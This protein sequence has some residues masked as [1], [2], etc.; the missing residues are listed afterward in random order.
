VV[1]HIYPSASDFENLSALR[2]ESSVEANDFD[3]SRV[4]VP[5]PWGYEY[6]WF[7]NSSVA[8][9]MLHLKPGCSTSLHCHARKRTSLIVMEG[10]VLCSTIDDRYHL[11]EGEAAVLEPCVFHSSQAISK[12]NVFLMEVETPPLKGD[13]LRSKDAFGRSGKAYESSSQYS[14]ELEK[15]DYQP[16][17]SIRQQEGTFNF[18]NVILSLSSFNGK[19]DFEDGLISGGI[20]VPLLG[21]IVFGKQTV[22]DIGEAITS[23]E[24]PL[25]ACPDSIP[26]V[27]LLQI[28]PMPNKQS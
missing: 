1:N 21:R 20:S 15:Y 22:A 2:T 16:L 8:I 13:L 27:E 4:V 11:K 18:K 19:S 7:Q 24:I 9:W 3:Y 5:K 28:V 10:N 14:T 6:L 25:G 26:P 23:S 17:E 12:E